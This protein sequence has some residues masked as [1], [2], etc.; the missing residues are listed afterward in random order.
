[1]KYTVKTELRHR[2]PHFVIPKRQ[3]TRP[4][5]T[6]KGLPRSVLRHKL[7]YLVQQDGA[8]PPE[9]LLPIRALRLS[10][11]PPV[12]LPLG[13]PPLAL[14]PPALCLLRPGLGLSA[15]LVGLLELLVV[16]PRATCPAA[17]A[18]TRAQAGLVTALSRRACLGCFF[19]FEHELAG[20]V[21]VAAFVLVGLILLAVVVLCWLFFSRWF[22]PLPGLLL[23]LLLGLNLDVLL[24]QLGLVNQALLDFCDCAIV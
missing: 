22:L 11:G 16:V 19:V 4:W 24:L 6:K 10:H 9:F 2:L 1:M 5:P 8:L 15:P 23:C 18:V 17:L 7:L 20:G 3:S 12:P 21:E 13:Q 14:H